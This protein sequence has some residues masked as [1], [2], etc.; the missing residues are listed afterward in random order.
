MG[1]DDQLGSD[2]HRARLPHLPQERSGQVHQR[3]AVS[4][5]FFLFELVLVVINRFAW[6]IFVFLRS[7]ERI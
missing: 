2:L 7:I 5:C 3:T 1:K 4:F 6:L